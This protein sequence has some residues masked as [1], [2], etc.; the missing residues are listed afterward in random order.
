MNIKELFSDKTFFRS[1]FTI[2]VPIML[3][4]L[5]NA[6]VN[7]AD[8]VMVGR[9]GTA[10]IAAVGLGN[11]VFFLYTM[12]LFGIGSGG[13]VF[14]AQFWGKQDLPGIRKTTG[15]SLTLAL[16]VAALFTLGAALAPGAVLAVYSRDPEVIRL[17]TVYLRTLAPCFAPF[18]VSFVFT[19]MMRSTERVRLPMVATLVSLSINVGLNVVLIFGAG[20]FPALGVQGAAIAT[21]AS[22]LVEMAILLTASYSRSYAMAGSLQELFGFNLAFARRFLV[23]AL[24]VIVNEMLWALGVTAQNVI[25][26]RTG[27]EA[28]AAF[29][30]TNTVSQLAWVFF[31]G[32]G[33]G[34]AVLIG[35][36][37]GEGSDATARRYA[38]LLVRF[39]PLS[40]A[41]IALFLVPM[42]W[43]LPY[44]FKVSPEVL[45]ITGGMFALLALSYPFRA[46]NMSMIIGVCRAGGDTVFSVVYDIVFMWLVSLPLAAAASFAF[47]APVWLIYLCLCV[48]DPL[49]M[50]L[51]LARLRSGKWLRDVTAETA[52]DKR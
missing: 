21:V 11:Q 28:I 22:R 18:A 3:Q 10:E 17:G 34:A 12:I 39:A 33:N 9:L 25:F 4:N 42:S 41:A 2:A 19:L 26:A 45:G 30:I 48:E 37:I 43:T 32:V 46:F 47:G 16:A 52:H 15:L 36:K 29:N 31:I 44:L 51:G 13:A 5:I 27:T 1:L 20:P 40:A 6:S 8:T 50:T 49:K 24:P 7:M 38:G 23:I 14:T 35:K